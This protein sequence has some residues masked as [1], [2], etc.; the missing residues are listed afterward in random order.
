MTPEMNLNST[1]SKI[2]YIHVCFICTPESQIALCFALLVIVFQIIEVFCFP[3]SYHCAFEI[4]AK[5]KNVKN[6][7]PKIS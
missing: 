3:I 6:Q 7:K 4:F 2:P 1:R 5:K